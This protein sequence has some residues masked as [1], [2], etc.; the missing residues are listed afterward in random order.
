MNWL[1]I[2]IAFAAIF[3]QSIAGFG[4]A[5]LAMSFLIGILG[6]DEARSTFAIAT[7]FSGLYFL[8]QYRAE[9]NWRLIFPLVIGSLVGIPLG[10]FVANLLDK[11]TFM[12]ILGIITTA[13]ALYSLSSLTMP[14]LNERWGLVFGLF[15]GLLHGA[16]NVGGSP[17]VMYGIS[18]RWRPTLFK[19]NTSVMFFVM[20][21]FIIAGHYQQ[22]NV[23]SEVWQ[24]VAIMVP[25]MF[26][27]MFLGF[28]LDRFI[29]PEPFRV[30]VSILLLLIGIK[31]LY[32]FF[33][34]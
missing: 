3:L 29:K 23:T 25:T 13:Y 20:G 22:G 26:V 30:G 18:Q 33:P 7:Q 28:S 32:E 6:P 11:E 21:I 15:S 1:V 8:Y 14:E 17:L 16:Y 2:P 10:F 19:C 5:L 4:S 27:A 34:L 24:N 31:T 9:W 12:I